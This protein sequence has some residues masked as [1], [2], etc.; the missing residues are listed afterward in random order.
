MHALCGAF[1]K[2]VY[3]PSHFL[4][5]IIQGVLRDYDFLFLGDRRKLNIFCI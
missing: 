1:L 2:P 4:H 3:I 5:L